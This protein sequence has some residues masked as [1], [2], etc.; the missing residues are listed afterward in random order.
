MKKSKIRISIIGMGYVGLPLAIEFERYYPVIGFDTNKDRIKNLQIYNDETREVSKINLKKAENLS[1]T[2]NAL[3]I[4]NCN[5]FIV[6]VPTPLKSN[7]TPNLSSL[8]KACKIVSKCLKT[9]DTVIF[10]STVYPGLTEEVCIP[11]IEKETGLKCNSDFQVGYS[12][13][14]VNPG[15]KYHRIENTIKITSGSNKYASKFIDNLYKKIVKVGTH[16]VSS[17]KAA[18]AAKIIENTQRD[19]NIALINELSM[20]FDKMGLNTYEI[21]EAAGTKWN[22]LSFEPGLVGGHCI[23]IDPYYLT[24]KAKKINF[25]PK[26]IL[27]GRYVNDHMAKY[28]GNK[29]HYLISKTK[30]QGKKILIMG[31][32]FKENCPDIRNSKVF[33]LINFLRNKK[34]KID[35]HDPCANPLNVKKEF[36]IKLLKEIKSKNYDAIFVSL[37]HDYYLKMGHNKIKNHLK[38]NGFIFDLKN[39]FN[40]NNQIIWK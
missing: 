28:F 2:N 20:I 12:P 17:I 22:F 7:N 15:D 25:D 13:E 18:E 29:I 36:D 9:N 38:K 8:K 30:N 19:L 34:Y 11:L 24:Y 21:L 3:D 1:F 23:G 32:T 26:V 39:A 10:E 27:S 16:R 14:R 33:E 40:L 37:A 4:K 5:V 31:V 35:V 6:C